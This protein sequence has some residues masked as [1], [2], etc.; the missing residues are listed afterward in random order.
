MT[1]PE[2]E[3]PAAAP[4]QVP[5]AAPLTEAD[6]ERT[7]RELSDKDRELLRFLWDQPDCKASESR[8]AKLQDPWGF[9]TWN[10]AIRRLGNRQLIER[11]LIWADQNTSEPGWA[12]VDLAKDLLA[13]QVDREQRAAPFEVVDAIPTLHAGNPPVVGGAGSTPR[14]AD[15]EIEPGRMRK[16]E[17]RFG[18]WI[19]TNDRVGSGGQGDA[20]LA[21]H[22]TDLAR[23]EPHVLKRL[24]NPERIKRFEKEVRAAL[25]LDH[26]GILRVVAS[27]LGTAKPYLVTPYCSGGELTFQFVTTLRPPE[28]LRL[29]SQISRAVGFAHSRGVVHRDLKPQNIL[30]AKNGRPVIADFGICYIKD[31]DRA[32]QT[33][34]AVGSRFCMP[35]ELE[36]GRAEVVSPAS[37][38]YC[39]GKLLYW[40]FAGRGFQREKQADP[41]LD[42]RAREPRAAHAAVHDLLDQLVVADP[43]HRLPDGNS[44]AAAADKQ[45][46]VLE[47]RGHALLIDL[48][49]ECHFCRL[50][51]YEI[52]ID[53]RWW[54]P[55]ADTRSP[56][57]GLQR[58][59]RLGHLY[60]VG[61][62]PNEPWLVL[63]CNR[64]GNVQKFQLFGGAPG[65]GEAW[66]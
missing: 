16:G 51:V 60:A 12:L 61:V 49:Q 35:P 55:G 7:W 53:P 23:T 59:E 40:M 33:L 62:R 48:P 65:F 43:K 22:H 41:E 26:P 14:V 28:R 42:L 31:E 39:L 44:V 19:K 1:A 30:I 4:S 66:K 50:G 46:E 24:R 17:R 25:M 52:R 34:E 54:G 47:G 63:Q 64:C 29:F 8:C 13:W 38:V 11:I 37:D 15:R 27:D 10:T 6:L 21:F 45:A 58:A 3:K 57:E 56:G 2:P 20:F 5:P 18:D 9:Q 36:D 32:T